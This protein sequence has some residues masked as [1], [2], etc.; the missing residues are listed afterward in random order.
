M[1]SDA[2]FLEE[3]VRAMTSSG[4]YRDMAEKELENRKVRQEIKMM[5]DSLDHC[6]IANVSAPR[7]QRFNTQLPMNLSRSFLCNKEGHFKR[8]CPCCNKIG[9]SFDINHHFVKHGNA[10]EVSR[11]TLLRHLAK[12]DARLDFS[13]KIDFDIPAGRVNSIGF[14]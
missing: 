13:W 9:D 14:C 6:K 12:C 8:D 5:F 1:K 10:D 7:I 3:K 2:C 4:M 11:K